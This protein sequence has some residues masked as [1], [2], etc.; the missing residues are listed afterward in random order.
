MAAVRRDMK[1]IYESG[2]KSSAGKV[3]VPPENFPHFLDLLYS[4]ANNDSDA[5]KRAM[6]DGEVIGLM[7]GKARPSGYNMWFRLK[8]ETED[9]FSIR[10]CFSNQIGSRDEVRKREKISM[11]EK[12]AHDEEWKKEKEKITDGPTTDNR[13][14]GDKRI[15]S[16]SSLRA[17][18]ATA[19]KQKKCNSHAE[20]DLMEKTASAI[21][22]SD[23]GHRTDKDDEDDDVSDTGARGEIESLGFNTRTTDFLLSNIE[24][25]YDPSTH[26]LDFLEEMLRRAENREDVVDI[27]A[28]HLSDTI[29][30][31]LQTVVVPGLDEDPGFDL[32]EY[33]IERCALRWEASSHVLPYWMDKEGLSRR[34]H[35]RLSRVFRMYPV[36]GGGGGEDDHD[37]D[38]DE[39][40]DDDR[41]RGDGGDGDTNGRAWLGAEYRSGWL[42]HG[43][44][45]DRLACFA[46]D[47]AFVKRSC[48]GQSH[49]DFSF[50]RSVYL[51]NDPFRS[52][53]HAI[54]CADFVIRGPSG[55]TG[56]RGAAEKNREDVADGHCYYAVVA[57][58]CNRLGFSSVV[59][60]LTSDLKW[61]F[62]P[63]VTGLS[64]YMPF[65]AD[66]SG[67]ALLQNG[68]MCNWKEVVEDC[69]KKIP[70]RLSR[71]DPQCK[72]KPFCNDRCQ[73]C[74]AARRCG[75][76]ASDECHRRDQRKRKSLSALCDSSTP[77]CVDVVEGPQSNGGGKVA[78]GAPHQLCIISHRA[79][80]T[81]D[82]F[83]RV[84]WVWS[85]DLR[86]G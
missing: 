58:K 86:L 15:A 84:M 35:G 80:A 73:S 62:D 9:D 66:A 52:M 27:A 12:E 1:K 74:S 29:V 25:G 85:Y 47:D 5:K 28:D 82:S 63:P 31:F 30:E 59:P 60:A 6:Q 23:K 40:E 56:R 54:R 77:G 21:V 3:S 76:S 55:R 18:A 61:A 50:G 46:E 36:G 42:F 16:A 22:V 13:I 8:D 75:C 33:I 38:E 11:R 17:A 48:L 32:A 24:D 51:T 72:C 14:I 26:A 10:H 64:V 70:H 2:V 81:F 53:K 20:H 65:G 83:E 68:D 43:G 69:R 7:V 45:L 57:V 37:E 49:Q 71:C 78:R 19:K 34:G 79:M 67:E 4:H 41:D 39:D 44:T